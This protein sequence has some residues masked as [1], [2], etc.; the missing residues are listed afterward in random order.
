MVNLDYLGP[1]VQV[2][3]HEVS[4]W[5]LRTNFRQVPA[6]PKRMKVLSES[7]KRK[8]KVPLVKELDSANIK[9]FDEVYDTVETIPLE[10]VKDF[11]EGVEEKRSDEMF[12]KISRHL[13]CATRDEHEA[14]K[15][16]S[17]RLFRAYDEYRIHSM[18]KVK[19]NF[20]HHVLK[21]DTLA[22]IKTDVH[23][24]IIEIRRDNEDDG[25][26]EKTYNHEQLMKFCNYIVNCKAKAAL[27]QWKA[28]VFGLGGD[29]RMGLLL[30]AE[31]DK[32][33][34]DFFKPVQD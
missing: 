26:N 17:K 14:H 13:S 27:R 15:R 3:H 21:A 6:S 5:M 18:G 9:T 10:S 16:D 33:R 24:E 20:K 4:G 2:K 32:V 8:Y 31:R 29:P 25:T 23:L 7:R 34:N 1:W 28:Q 30:V 19:E 11:T 22:K 12:R